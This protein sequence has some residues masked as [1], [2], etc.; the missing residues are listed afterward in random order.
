MTRPLARLG[1]ASR[2]FEP[3]ADQLMFLLAS[4]NRRVNVNQQI[5]LDLVRLV[6]DTPKTHVDVFATTFDDT[7]RVRNCIY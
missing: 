3:I 1:E 6:P 4:A 5:R 7:K 2:V